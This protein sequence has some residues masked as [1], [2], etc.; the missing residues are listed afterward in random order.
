MSQNLPRYPIR[1]FVNG[2]L[3][4]ERFSAS[5][6]TKLLDVGRTIAEPRW[7]I[8]QNLFKSF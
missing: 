1:Q 3:I 2:R 7:A 8:T 6:I 4:D 5:C